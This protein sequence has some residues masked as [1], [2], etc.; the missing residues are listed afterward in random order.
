MPPPIAILGLALGG[1]DEPAAVEPYLYQRFSDP[2]APVFAG[3]PMARRLLARRLARRQAPTLRSRYAGI[4]GASPALTY[5]LAQV[6]GVVER[7]N[8]RVGE[9]RYRGYVAL[10]YWVPFAGDAL[11]RMRADG[12]ERAVLLPLFPQEAQATVGTMVRA[13][14]DALGELDAEIAWSLVD[15]WFDHPA[16]LGVLAERIAATLDA[17]PPGETVPVL[18]SAFGIP[19]RALHRGEPYLAQVDATVAGLAAR[20]P[21]RARLEVVHQPFV[22]RADG[23]GEHLHVRLRALGEAG[24]RTVVTAPIHPLYD[25]LETLFDLDLRCA[26]VAREAGIETYLRAST[27]NDDPRFLDALTQIVAAHLDQRPPPIA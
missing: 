1:P 11:R 21:A 5:A 24:A 15:P 3:G 10:R 27:L 17:V 25:D 13:V 2:L 6:E 20:L 7:L 14:R 8:R 12:V 23:P 16:Y 18:C 26:A 9:K 4:G 19:R 22:G